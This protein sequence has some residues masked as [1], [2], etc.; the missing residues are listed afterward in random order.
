MRNI[1]LA[2]IISCIAAPLSAQTKGG[3]ATP[4]KALLETGRAISE[5]QSSAKTESA[6]QTS[7]RAADNGRLDQLA[8]EAQGKLAKPSDNSNSKLIFSVDQK[9]EPA[10][11]SATPEGR[12]IIAQSAAAP[13]V[14]A[15]EPNATKGSAPAP[16]PLA[17]GASDGSKNKTAET[18]AKDIDIRSEGAVYLDSA[19]ALAIF[20]DDVV[21]D[22]PTFH[23]TCDKL[24]VYFVKEPSQKAAPV[25]D[26]PAKNSAD[27]AANSKT[28]PVDP[29][30]PASGD[31]KL[32]Q[33]IGT[34]KKV[35]VRKLDERGEPQIG[36]CRHLTYIGE[37]GDVILREMP[38]VQRGNNVIIAREPSTYMVMKQNGELKVH[39]PADTKI[40]QKPDAGGKP[41]A[42]ALAP[43]G[44][45]P[46][47][48]TLTPKKTA[49]K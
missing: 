2:V 48:P 44:A 8:T 45:V 38:Q 4:Q 34:G 6:R 32:K 12:A 42:P 35:V 3:V 25:K 40:Q 29:A 13:A 16:K 21:V 31:A 47:A 17:T 23:M 1:F 28:P 19:Q 46:G 10:L 7:D 14:R 36:I 27:S 26:A 9:L 15:P 33:A 49:K 11:R 41:A 20:T 22:H 5:A 39:G 18:P 37:S 30:A 43:S 24:E